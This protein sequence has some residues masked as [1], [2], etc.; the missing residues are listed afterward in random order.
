LVVVFKLFERLKFRTFFYFVFK[1]LPQSC[2]VHAIRIYVIVETFMAKLPVKRTISIC[3]LFCSYV[4]FLLHGITVFNYSGRV[5]Y[6]IAV[7]TALSCI[8]Y[9][10]KLRKSSFL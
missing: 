8:F 5:M 10:W 3:I 2:W 7:S 9:W 6:I 4:T 1:Q